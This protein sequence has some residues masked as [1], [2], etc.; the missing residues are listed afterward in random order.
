MSPKIHHILP[1]LGEHVGQQTIK[2]TEP[3]EGVTAR[4]GMGEELLSRRYKSKMRDLEPKDRGEREG[5][6]LVV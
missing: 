4:R 1:A 5:W 3:I 6:K 2:H